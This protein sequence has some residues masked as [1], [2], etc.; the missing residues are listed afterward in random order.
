MKNDSNNRKPSLE[1]TEGE[2]GTRIGATGCWGKFQAR[3]FQSKLHPLLSNLQ[4][5]LSLVL[6][7]CAG[8]V[9]MSERG[10]LKKERRVSFWCP[11]KPR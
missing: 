7:K 8:E 3:G 6:G 4:L 9:G 2:N 10:T 1:I 5:I 11:F